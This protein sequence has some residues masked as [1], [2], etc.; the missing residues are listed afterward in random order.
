MKMQ[1]QSLALLSGSGIWHFW[2]LWTRLQMRLGSGF[3]VAMCRL[4]AEV[5]ISLLFFFFF[6][7]CFLLFLLGLCSQH[8][9]VPR[10][11][12]S[13]S[14]W[15]K[16]QP[17]QCAIQASSSTSTRAHG[18]ARSLTHWVR[19]GIEPASSWI[20]VR[21]MSAAQREL[22]DSTPS[23]GTSVCCG[24]SPKETKKKKREPDT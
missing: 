5:L 14:C 23:L 24:C 8:M 10:S 7:F 1:A 21:F 3:A 15:P 2:E 20:L 9:E 13:Y 22:P 17:R 4:V 16:P 11:N 12:W 6:G 18:N 19:P